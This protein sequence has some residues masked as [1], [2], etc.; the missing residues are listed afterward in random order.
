[1]CTPMDHEISLEPNATA[2]ARPLHGVGR[3]LGSMLGQMGES[4]RQRK[5]DAL[6]RKRSAEQS[7]QTQSATHSSRTP[8]RDR[9]TSS[10][11]HASVGKSKG[12]NS[13]SSMKKNGRQPKVVTFDS[14]AEGPQQAAMQDSDATDSPGQSRSFLRESC[15]T[16]NPLPASSGAIS[17]VPAPCTSLV[18]TGAGSNIS[19]EPP[20]DL[21]TDFVDEE[22]LL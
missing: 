16:H 7:S 13:F 15:N 11:S 1:M 2:E 18:P 14:S 10:V 8:A 6:Q 21:A 22:D 3:I 20:M 5:L 12:S 9:S 4:T 19:Q 17:D